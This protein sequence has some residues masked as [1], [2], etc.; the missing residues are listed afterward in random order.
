LFTTKTILERLEIEAKGS[1][2]L[3]LGEI[4]DYYA[5]NDSLEALIPLYRD[6]LVNRGFEKE[7]VGAY[8]TLDSIAMARVLL[9]T[10][11]L[12][13]TNDTLFAD[14]ADLYL[15]MV[16]D[17]ISW[18]QL[19]SVQA[20]R[21]VNLSRKES[22]IQSY[23]LAARALRGDTLYHRYPQLNESSSSRLA[24]TSNTPMTRQIKQDVKVYPNPNSGSFTLELNL[25][26]A[27][28]ITWSIVDL[29]GRTLQ[30]GF[31]VAQDGESRTQ[32]DISAL[33]NGMYLIGL[34][35][36][37]GTFIHTKRITLVK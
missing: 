31:F 37:A 30:N 29:T 6:S 7:L 26:Q 25:E 27:Q 17:S 3:K 15:D 21:L 20:L 5:A 32:L 8:L 33:K 36:E 18:L 2:Y 16:E 12:T 23:A 1:W 22:V 24:N 10:L 28:S 34:S 13:T 9:D 4:T 11:T 35:N 19:D 14:Y